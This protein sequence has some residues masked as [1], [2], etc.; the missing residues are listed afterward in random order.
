MFKALKFLPIAS[1][2]G[3]LLLFSSTTWAQAPQIKSSKIFNSVKWELWQMGLAED[4]ND[5]G[6]ELAQKED[7]KSFKQEELHYPEELSL[8]LSKIKH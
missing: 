1:F 2:F 4:N 6:Q 5:Q 8:A 7:E 3:A